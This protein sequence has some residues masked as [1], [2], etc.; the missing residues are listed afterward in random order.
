MTVMTDAAVGVVDQAAVADMA[1][2]TINI[3]HKREP[4]GSLFHYR[5]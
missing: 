1:T 4:S 3:H 2:A 5:A